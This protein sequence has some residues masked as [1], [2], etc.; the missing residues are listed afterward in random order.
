MLTLLQL[1]L[2]SFLLLLLTGWQGSAQLGRKRLSGCQ[3]VVKKAC[4]ASEERLTVMPVELVQEQTHAE[5][6]ALRP[7]KAYTATHEDSPPVNKGIYP[8]N[9][10]QQHRGYIKPLPRHI[11]RT[12]A[13]VEE[14]AAQH[15]LLIQFRRIVSTHNDSKQQQARFHKFRVKECVCQDKQA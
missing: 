11:L 13:P 1:R 14:D 12:S 2:L 6:A 4:N 3:V 8:A 10:R 9:K 5:L 15:R 7:S